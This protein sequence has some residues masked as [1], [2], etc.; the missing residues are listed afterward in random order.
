[1]NEMVKI[2]WINE[3]KQQQKTQKKNE[4]PNVLLHTKQ[5]NTKNENKAK[6]SFFD[7]CGQFIKFKLVIQNVLSYNIKEMKNK[8]YIYERIGMC[9]A[10]QVSAISVSV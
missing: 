5:T 6:K 7:L 10:V 1:M 4:E 2:N 9:V 3:R 8:Y